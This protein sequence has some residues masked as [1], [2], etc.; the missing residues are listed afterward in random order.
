MVLVDDLDELFVGVFWGFGEIVG[1]DVVGDFGDLVLGKNFF[2]LLH[3][4]L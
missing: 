1:D 2:G 3:F 4:L